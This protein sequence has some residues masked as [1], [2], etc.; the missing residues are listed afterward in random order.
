[1]KI[2]SLDE[3][4]E[5]VHGDKGPELKKFIVN[6]VTKTVDGNKGILWEDALE[7]EMLYHTKRLSRNAVGRDFDDDSDAK[8][9]T[10]YRKK[11]GILEASISGIRNKIGVL[12]VCLCVPGETYHRLMFMR[13]PPKAYLKYAAGSNAIKITL[14]KTGNVQGTLARY[15]CNFKEVAAPIIK[16]DN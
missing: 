8:F 6:Q 7:K 13:I 2:R 9:A 10:F 16:K 12:R 11:S 4:I 5:F 3:L 15:I 14:S 1:M